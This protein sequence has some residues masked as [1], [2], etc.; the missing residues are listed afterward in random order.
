[1]GLISPIKSLLPASSRSLHGMYQE[2]GQMHDQ[3]K[4]MRTE[5]DQTRTMANDLLSQTRQIRSE[6]SSNDARAMLLLWELHRRDGESIGE[7]MRRVLSGLS[8]ATGDMRLYQLA[9]AQLLFEFDVFCKGHGLTYWL[10]SGTLL[11]AVRHGGFIPWDD[12]LDVGMPRWDIERAMELVKDDP[13]YVITVRYDYYVHCRQVRFRYADERIPCFIDL[14]F[15]DPVSKI[16]RDTLAA[17]EA[18]RAALEAELVADETLHEFW[19]EAAQFVDEGTP[20]AATIKAHFD[21]HIAN[22][23][24]TGVLSDSLDE[25]EG[26]IWTIDNVNSGVAHHSWY[27]TPSERVFPLAR[28]GF[29]GHEVNVPRDSTYCLKA[30]FGDIYD[31][32]KKMGSYFDHLLGDS[33]TSPDTRAELRRLAGEERRSS[34][35]VE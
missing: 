14:F 11:G 6:L 1:M 9:S 31:L 2:L 21:D 8:P 4:Q 15:F 16:G 10:Q 34:T 30:I 26:V 24:E 23:Y 32:P 33:L 5:I 3:M 29:E 12:D 17:R 20:E 35:S 28:M 18:E 25:A 7:T 19:N 13:R 27:I 22:L